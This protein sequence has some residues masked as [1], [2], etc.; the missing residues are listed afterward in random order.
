MSIGEC[1]RSEDIM[2]VKLEYMGE[3]GKESIYVYYRLYGKREKW[4]IK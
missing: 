3:N 1:D 2:P 4:K